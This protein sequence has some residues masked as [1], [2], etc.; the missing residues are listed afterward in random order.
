MK[1]DVPI[2]WNKSRATSKAK[3]KV[4]RG[5]VLLR[6]SR[7]EVQRKDSIKQPPATCIIVNPICIGDRTTS[8]TNTD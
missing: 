6:T 7:D 4:E 8:S 3:V 2:D 1:T 5:K